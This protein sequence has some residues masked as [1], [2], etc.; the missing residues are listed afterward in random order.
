L[1]GTFYKASD[2]IF[3]PQVTLKLK[4]KLKMTIL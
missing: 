1:V 2:M 3:F 4:L